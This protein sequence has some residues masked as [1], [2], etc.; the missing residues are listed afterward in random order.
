MKKIVWT[1][2]LISGLIVSGWMLSSI[3]IGF[4]QMD[5]NIAMFLGFTAMII[6]FSFIFVAVKNFRDNLN[7]G[8]VTFGKAFQIGLLVSLIASTFYVV[9]WLVD[10]YLF[11]PDFMEKYSAHQLEKLQQSGATAVEIQSQ[12]AEIQSMKEMYKN[13]LFVIMFTYIEILPIGLLISLITAFFLKKK[14]KSTMES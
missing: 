13:P 4:D 11:I 10:Y 2:G 7:N 8:T 12:T 5:S 1:Y 6:A 9:S 14:Y 3:A